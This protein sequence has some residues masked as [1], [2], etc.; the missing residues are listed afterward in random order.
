MEH[1]LEASST[2]L[3][4]FLSAVLRPHSQFWAI[5]EGITE[6]IIEGTA[7]LT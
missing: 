3:V 7:S 1:P 2:L 6:A 4:I 5:I